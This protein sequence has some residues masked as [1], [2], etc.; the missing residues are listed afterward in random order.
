[1]KI[2][3]PRPDI[4][5]RIPKDDH[6]VIEASAGTGKTYTIEHLFIELLLSKQASID[7][8]L[9]LTFTERAAS[10]LRSR[11]RSMIER[12]IATPP[13]PQSPGGNCWEIDPQGKVHLERALF[14]FDMAP[15]HTIHSFFQRVVNEHAFSSGRLFE[16]SLVDSRSVFQDAF[17]DTLRSEFSCKP[18]FIPYLQA[19]L[20]SGKTIEDLQNELYQCHAKKRPILPEFVEQA[21][22]QA[23]LTLH[24]ALQAGGLAEQFTT[25]AKDNG[26]GKSV[27]A[28]V[29][30]IDQFAVMLAGIQQS[31]CM[32]DILLGFDPEGI[33]FTLSRVSSA[34]T[35]SAPVMTYIDALR[36]LKKHYVSL[37]A[38]VVGLF[39]RE[40]QKRLEQKK[41][42]EGLYD[43]DDMI[44]HLLDAVTGPQQGALI[45]AL[46]ARFR[47]A[48]IDE[49]QDTDQRQWEIFERIFVKSRPPA[50]NIL[51][52]VGDPK[53]AI[54]G[55]RGADVQTY[56][57]ARKALCSQRQPVPLASN[58]RSTAGLINAFNELFRQDIDAPFFQ[59]EIRY[60]TPLQCGN[61]QFQALDR[62]GQDISPVVIWEIGANSDDEVSA[63]YYKNALGSAIAAEIP[64]L[65]NGGLVGLKASDIFIL[66]RS[67]SEGR[68]VAHYLRKAGLPY[69]FYKLDGLFETPQAQ[70]ILDLLL[71][72]DRPFDESRRL[73]A[74]LTPFFDMPLDRLLHCKGL[75]E[76]DLLV[77]RLLDWHALA[78]RR[79]FAA[80][81]SSI[82]N[83]SGIVR[84]TIFFEE[85][86]RELTDYLH[87]IELLMEEASAGGRELSDINQLL[88]DYIA[89][90]RTPA[91]DDGS[92]QRLET[93]KD[94]IQIMTMHKSKGLEASVV[95][96]YGG[97]SKRIGGDSYHLYHDDSGKPV[98]HIDG[99]SETKVRAEAESDDEDRR[100]LYVATTRAKAR[101][102]LPYVHPKKYKNPGMYRLLNGR[103]AAILAD[104]DTMKQKGF[105]KEVPP[106]AGDNAGTKDKA[107]KDVVKQWRPS[108]DLLEEIDESEQFAML[109]DQHA[110]FDVTSYSHM[111]MMMG[112]YA[113]PGGDEERIF[114]DRSAESG[115]LT[116][117]TDS[118]AGPRFG[119]VL[120]ALMEQVA[121]RGIVHADGGS[122]EWMMQASVRSLAMK[123]L[124]REGLSEQH[125]SFLLSLVYNALTSKIQLADGTILDRLTNVEQMAREVEFL[126]PYPEDSLPGIAVADWPEVR[127]GRGFVKGFIDMV[128][129]YGG[130]LHL[131]DWKSDILPDYSAQSLKDHF[132]QHYDLQ[133]K[134]YLVALC[135][136][137]K[138]HTEDAYNERI[139]SV[140]YCFVR[141]MKPDGDANAGVAVSRP[142][143][144]DL[145]AFEQRLISGAMFVG[146]QS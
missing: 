139:G 58:Y 126:Y 123:A 45:T 99:T 54:Y 62:Q 116:V 118:P 26:L 19:W 14:S 119:K 140:V 24:A 23:F 7:S 87:I 67:E 66:T 144:D 97:Y 3:Y 29:K 6:T 59:G 31:S 5:D 17:L 142:S 10:E 75:P 89:K 145:L 12:V 49:S 34:A 15:I 141:G 13:S 73:R 80:L 20:A 37:K 131:L 117:S 30:R 65:L 112:G 129:T 115:K 108:S 46:R 9:V 127:I 4:L 132:A 113:A 48:L 134:L 44:S 50:Q 122:A 114:D 128:F 47:Y 53:Q 42:A 63:E 88:A 133:S 76:S 83:E 68:R 100:L 120:H 18:R 82:I 43:Y 136:I 78:L 143:W 71:A 96:L 138:V 110:G 92:V 102:Y 72:I 77:K 33:E 40:V 135:R 52:L 121:F 106:Y 38:A 104:P 51:Y 130:K 28:L 107:D 105:I 93:D 69:A 32:A 98:L 103:L 60:E 16:Q 55:F 56:L 90:T 109:R 74:W 25:E 95:F 124:A 57:A 36:Q 85:S 70:H 64:K 125:A 39:L 8:I 79:N 101:L 94:A 91:R 22:M 21:L 11:V 35:W 27:S 111:K 1:M 86:E 2:F 41:R 146:R 84:R 61:P 81:F 137:L